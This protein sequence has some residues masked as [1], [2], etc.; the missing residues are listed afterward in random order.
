M[1][2]SSFLSPKHHSTSILHRTDTLKVDS[3]LLWRK[4]FFPCIDHKLFEEMDAMTKSARLSL[5]RPTF[6]LWDGNILKNIELK[7]RIPGFHVTKAE[8]EKAFIVAVSV[9]NYEKKDVEW[10]FDHDKRILRLKGKKYYIEGDMQVKSSF[11]EAILLNH[12]I[13]A[14][15]IHAVLSDGTLTITAPKMFTAQEQTT[16]NNEATTAALEEDAAVDEI[17]VSTGGIVNV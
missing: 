15:K 13:D 9:P 11:E 5:Q 2:F 17:L 10:N 14:S 16:Q 3:P 8:D 1:T 7:K 4:Q 6:S 12:D